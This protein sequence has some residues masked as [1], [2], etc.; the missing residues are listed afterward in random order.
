MLTSTAPGVTDLV[1]HAAIPL[2]GST[3]D[4]DSLLDLIGDARFVLLGEASH[5]T[6]E[7]YRERAKITKRL[8]R[9]KGFNAIALEADWPDAYRVHRYVQGDNTDRDAAQALNG[10]KRFPSWMWRNADFLDFVGWLRTHNDALEPSR[11][12]GLFGLD[13]YSL[14][15]SIQCVLRYLDEIDPDAAHKARLR[16]ACFDNFGGDAQAYGYATSL[17]L[18]ASCKDEVISQ[19]I[20]LQH[21][22]L[23]YARMDGLAALERF[24]DTKQNAQVVKD[25]EE[26][27]RTMFLGAV[28]SWNLRDRHMAETLDALIEHLD[29]QQPPAKLVVWAHNS[30]VGDARATQMGH[31][32]EWNIGQLVRQK[33]NGECRNIGFTTYT[34]T[35]TAAS[36]W[37]GPAERKMVRPARNDSF[38][39]LF[40]QT[41]IPAFSLSLARQT[42]VAKRL[43]ESMLERAIGVVYLPATE[44]ASHYF[45]ASLSDQFDAVIHFDQTRAVE[46]MEPISAGDEGEP[47]E[48]FPSGI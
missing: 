5:G 17:G 7:F 12:I 48:T 13:L 21:S 2:N 36:G 11:R 34:G 3:T 31:S 40:H 42:Q 22:S 37:D 15:A 44:L 9:E 23:R 6:H 41:G 4:Y 28:S 1:H 47:P 35:V 20:D 32:G 19:L 33:Y 29:R 46:P 10:F 14:H 43:A 25:A 45:L 30:H 26:Y 18:R 27:Y 38:E 24:F 8:I 39:G 16:Y